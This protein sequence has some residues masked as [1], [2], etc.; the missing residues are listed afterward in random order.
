MTKSPQILDE[1]VAEIPV[2]FMVTNAKFARQPVK[3]R[4]K[5]PEPET[6]FYPAEREKDARDA[7]RILNADFIP[8]YAHC[9]PDNIRAIAE[10]VKELKT[11][12]I[13]AEENDKISREFLEHS[14]KRIAELEGENAK[15]RKSISTLREALEEIAPYFED[16]A[17]A[18][19]FTDSPIPVGNDEMKYLAVT[20]NALHLTRTALQEGK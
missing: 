8:L 9:S 14:D 1:M 19:Y 3:A 13:R 16:R 17:D 2:A 15:L 20:Q 12:L 4:G 7:A 10:Y 5:F 6:M 18:E 11:N